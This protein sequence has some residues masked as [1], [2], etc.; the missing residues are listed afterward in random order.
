MLF[1]ISFCCIGVCGAE[2]S[3]VMVNLGV[4]PIPCGSEGRSVP[5]LEVL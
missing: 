3:W 1:V 4:I 5:G 2:V